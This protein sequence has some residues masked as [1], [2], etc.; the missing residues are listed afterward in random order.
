MWT[1]IRKPCLSII[2]NAMIITP[3]LKK[4]VP[5]HINPASHLIPAASPSL[6]FHPLPS[7]SRPVQSDHREAAET[8]AVWQ[9]E[10]IIK[11]QKAERGSRGTQWVIA[12]QTHTL[13]PGNRELLTGGVQCGVFSTGMDRLCTPCVRYHLITDQWWRPPPP[14]THIHTHLTVII[15]HESI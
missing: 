10:R 7:N 13:G 8:A 12:P 3:N 4:R 11:V 6:P 5:S 9:V 2:C 14:H 15:L 1:T